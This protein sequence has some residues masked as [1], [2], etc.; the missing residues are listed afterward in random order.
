MKIF[1][2]SLI[3]KRIYKKLLKIN[4]YVINL[5]KII[6]NFLNKVLS[7][8]FCKNIICILIKNMVDRTIFKKI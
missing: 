7:L 4:K 6:I 3:C 8:P 2:R 1:I 5:L